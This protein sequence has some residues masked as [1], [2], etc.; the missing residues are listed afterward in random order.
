[1]IWLEFII[2]EADVI[3]LEN[4]SF[5]FTIYKRGFKDFKNIHALLQFN[6][7]ML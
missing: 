5:T 6:T 1:M 4:R 7:R 2:I 3:S